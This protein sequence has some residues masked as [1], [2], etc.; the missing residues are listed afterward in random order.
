MHDWLWIIAFV[1]AYM[2]LT[3]WILAKSGVPT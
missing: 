1:V 2:A 3:R